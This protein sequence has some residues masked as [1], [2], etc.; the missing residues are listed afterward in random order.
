MV[1]G[2]SGV[3]LSFLSDLNNCAQ[4]RAASDLSEVRVA[5]SVAGPGLPAQEWRSWKKPSPQED[6]HWPRRI[7][8]GGRQDE[9]S[10]P[11]VHV[12]H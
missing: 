1:L 2:P 3:W 8:R 6:T 4:L 11:L 10:S 7:S 5:F 9:H 12:E